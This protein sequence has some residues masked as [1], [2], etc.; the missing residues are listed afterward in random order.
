M[1]TVM[2]AITDDRFCIKVKLYPL[3]ICNIA[4]LEQSNRP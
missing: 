2:G 4:R 1:S 3:I